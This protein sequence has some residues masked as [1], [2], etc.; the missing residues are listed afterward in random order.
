MERYTGYSVSDDGRVFSH[1]KRCNKE[2]IIDFDRMREL[3]PSLTRKGYRRV[4]LRSQG[5]AVHR[6]VALAFIPNPENK[7]QVNHKDGD[8]TNNSVENL[9]W[10]TGQENHTHKLEHG[11]NVVKRGSEHYLYGRTGTQHPVTKRVR[12][13]D[14]QGNEVRVFETMTDAGKSLET[15]YSLISKC[16]NG[17]LEKAYGYKWEFI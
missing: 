17:K 5:F 7:P 10:V 4:E 14:L 3:R 9:E 11:L 2:W 6:L 8:K 12:Q 16:C 15:H 1:I 13:M